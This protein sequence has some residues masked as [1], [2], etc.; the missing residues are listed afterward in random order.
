MTIKS[1]NHIEQE[2]EKSW[3]GI[4]LTFCIY[5]IF[6]ITNSKAAI[7]GYA[8]FGGS[9][10]TAPSNIS[11]LNQDTPHS[12]RWTK[13][14]MDAD[15]FSHDT[16]SFSHE[17]TFKNAGN[18]RVS[19]SI[20]L[21]E[22][23][24]GN[25]RSI[26]AELYLNGNPIDAGR[27][28]SS[29]IR[30][31]NGHTKTSLHFSSLL[32]NISVDDILELRVSK[33]TNQTG[34][35]TTPGAQ[36]FLQKIEA[37]EAI[38]FLKGDQ[39]TA[40]ADLNT[41]AERDFSWDEAPVT[42]AAYSHST[43]SN[44]NQVTF[45]QSGSYRV[46][47]NIPLQDPS[48][49]PGN[50]RTA[51]EARVRVGGTLVTSGG[52]TQG[53]IRCSDNHQFSSI[54]W[55]GY[56]H[57]VTPGQ[58]LTVDVI[59]E[60]TVYSTVNVPSG[61]KASLL[62]EKIDSSTKTLTLS[63]TTLTTGNNWNETAGGSVQ[64]T[65]QSVKDAV[66]YNHST[67][68]NSH[69]ITFSESGDYLVTYS[70]SLTST[71]ARAN[72]A[73]QLRLNN[74]LPD[75]GECRSHYIRN[76]NGH[77]QSSCSMV[78]LLENVSNGDTLEVSLSASAA[79]GTVNDQRPAEISIYQISAQEP[80]LDIGNIPNKS[81]HFDMSDNANVLDNSNRNAND[82]SFSTN[83]KTLV[84]IS[85][86][87]FPH[88]GEQ[89]NTASQPTFDKDTN[90]LNFDG[91]NDF[92]EIANAADINTGT[93]SERTFA[94][95]FRTGPDV[96]SRQMIYEEGGTV[97]G[98][99]VYIGGGN[100]YLG[101]WNDNNDGD[102]RQAFVSTS[103]AVAPNTNYYV[104]IV[105]DYSNYT[106][107]NGPNGAL[108][109]T[110]N[111]T[112]FTFSGSTTSR[113]YNHPGAIGVGAMNGGTCYHDGCPGGNGDYF[114]G[115][116]F[117]FIM[118][119]AAISPA[120]E[121]EYYNFFK[122]KW[123][124]PFPVTNLQ[125][126]DQ[127]INDSTTTP[128]ITWD[129]SISTDIDHYEVA[130]GTAPELSDVE[131][132]TNVGNVTSTTVTG[133]SLS[134]CVNYFASVKAVDPEPKES[135]LESTSFFKYDG[136]S[137]TDP[138]GL[139]L[140]SSASG[141]TSRILTWNGV[142]DNCSFERYE[143]ALGTTSGGFDIVN[144]T[145]VGTSLSHQFTGLTLSNG[146]DYY[147]SVRAV[148]SAEN[149]SNEVS[150]VAWQVD[151]CVASDVTAP[152][153]PSALTL[154]GVAGPTSSPSLSWTES[155]DSCGFSHY[156]IAIGTTSGA[157]DVQPFTNIGNVLSYKYFSLTPALNTNTDYY[158]SLKAVDLNNNQSSIISS[159]VWSLPAPGNVSSGLVL[160]LDSDDQSTFFQ[161]NDCSTG[162]VTT[163]GD[164]IG[165]W[166]DKSQS[167]NNA[168]SNA[169]N[170]RPTYQTNEFNGKSIVRFDGAND[171]LNFTNIND[172]RTVFIV[173]KSTGTT[174][175]PLM[176]HSTL[177]DWFTNDTSLVT[178]GA[179]SFLTGGTW[180]FNKANVPNPQLQTQNGQYSLYSVVTTGNVS[181]DHISSD[182]KTGGRYFGGDYVEVIVYDRALN[183]SE[184]TA[185]E[186]FLFDKWFSA[187]PGELTGL[188]LSSEYTD[189]ATVTPSLSWDHSLASDLSFYEVALGTSQGQN[190]IAGWFNIGLINNYQFNGST[191]A[192][193]TPH[194]IS[195]RA[196]DADGNR[197]LATSSGPFRFDGTAPTNPSSLVL[198]GNASASVSR[199]LTWAS[200]T[201]ACSDHVYELS[202]GTG[203]GATDAA[204]WTDVGNINTYQFSGLTLTPATNYYFNIRAKD[205]AGNLS[206]VISSSSWQVASCVATDTTAPLPPTNINATGTTELRSTPTFTWTSGSDACAFARHDVSIG[207]SAGA[208]DVVTW[209]SVGTAT[210]HQFAALATNLSYDTDY[211]FNVKSVDQ[212]NN[213]SSTL[214]SSAFRLVGP[215]SVSATNLALWINVD[216]AETL[217]QNDNCTTVANSNN[218]NVGCIKDLSGN[219]NH[220]TVNAS[221]NKPTLRTNAFNGKNA[222][223]FDGLTNEYLNFTTR[224]T[225]IRTV[226]WVL[227]ED[228]SRLGNTVPLLGDPN[229]GTTDFARDSTGG[230]FFNASTASAAVTGG[231]LKV[232]KAAANTTATTVP[233]TESAVSLV[234]TGNT[235]A[236]SFTRDLVSC[237]GNRTFGGRLAELIIF[238][239][240]LSPAE[241]EDVEDYLMSKWNL[242]N[243]S[244][245]WLGSVSTDWNNAANWSA[246]VPTSSLDCTIPDRAN[247]PVI[248]SGIA[249]CRNVNI[250]NGNLTLQGGGGVNLRFYGDFD[251]Q[252][253]T[254]TSNDGVITV[255]DNGSNY[256]NH[257]LNLNGN[258]VNLSFNKSAG[259]GVSINENTIFTSLNIPV[260]S[261]LTLRIKRDL[262][263]GLPNGLTQQGGIIQIERGV[264]F[265]IG[266]N[267]KISIS[268]GS[269]ETQGL[270][271][272][273]SQNLTTKVTM[274]SSGRWS[275]EANGG[276]IALVGFILDKLDVDGLQILGN[277]NLTALDGG[278]FTNLLKDFTT[279]VKAVTLN[280]TA[281]MSESVAVNVGFNW[282]AANSGYAGDPVPGDNY[283]TV[284]ANNCGGGSLVFD[285]WFGDFWGAPTSFDTEDKI[286]DNQDGGN[287]NVSMDIAVSPVSLK[288]FYA[289]AYDSKILLEWETGFE[290]DH[291]GF[292]IY[293]TSNP[294]DGYNQIN[295]ELIRNYRTGGEFRGKYRFEDPDL[296]NGEV[297]FYILEDV[298][299]NGD[300]EQHGPVFARPD[301]SYGNIPAPDDSDINEPIQD[302]GSINLGGGVALLSQTKGSFR[303]SINPGVLQTTTASWDSNYVDVSIPGYSHLSNAESPQLLVRKILVPVD[304]SYS[305]VQHSA[306]PPTVRDESAALGG[307]SISPAPSYSQNSD[308]ELVPFYQE[309]P[310][311][312][313]SNSYSP[314]LYYQV[315]SQTVEILNKHYV[316]ITVYPLRYIASSN[317]LEKLDQLILDIGLKGNAWDYTPPSDIYEV[318]PHIAEGS[319]RIKYSQEG[320]YKLAFSD[321]VDINADGFYNEVSIEDL[322]LYRDGKELPLK[323]Q[324]ADATFGPGDNLLFYGPYEKSHY[325]DE[326]EVVLSFYDFDV[327]D[328]YSYEAKRIEAI[329]QNN[330]S[331]RGINDTNTKSLLFADNNNAFDGMP[332]GL[333]ED[334]LY[335]VRLI[336]VKGGY[337]GAHEETINLSDLSPYTDYLTVKMKVIGSAV[338]SKNPTHNLRLQID[339]TLVESK[340]FK[341]T[342]PTMVSFDVPVSYLSNGNNVFRFSVDGTELK[343]GDIEFLFVDEIEVTYEVENERQGGQTFLRGGASRE[344]VIVNNIQNPNVAVYDISSPF[345]VFEYDTVFSDTFD[346]GSTYQVSF[347]SQPGIDG[348]GGRDKIVVENNAYLSPERIILSEGVNTVLKDSNNEYSYVIIAEPHLL[349]AAQRLA[350][351]KINDGL[352]SLAVST[353]QIYGEFSGGRKDPLALQKFVKFS[354]ENWSD[355]LDYLLIIGDASFDP[356]DDLGYSGQKMQPLLF[357]SGAQEDYGSD[358]A[359]GFPQLG[360]DEEGIAPKIAVG[361]L[362]TSNL[363][364][365]ESYIQKVI[366]YESGAK[367]PSTNAK[368][369]IFVAGSSDDNEDFERGTTNLIQSFLS[370]NEEFS[371]SY[372][373]R[374]QLTNAET[375]A[376]LITSINE[377]PLLVS[378]LGHGAENQWGLGVGGFFKNSDAEA[379]TNDKLP[380]MMGF[381]CRNTYFYN[382]DLSEISLAE[383]L[384]LNPQGGAIAFFGSTTFTGPAAQE[385]LATSLINELGRRS[386]TSQVGT[387]IGE[388]ALSSY[389]VM[390]SNIYEK[391]MIMSWALIGD[392]T[393]K[394]PESSFS[395]V[396]EAP[397]AAQPGGATPAVAS[398]GRGGGCSLFADEGSNRNPYNGWLF[399]L[400]LLL[401]CSIYSLRRTFS[402]KNRKR[403][404]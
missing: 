364:F 296:Q 276:S 46:S 177:T 71:V 229:G 108:R 73:V 42:N 85:G 15:F 213:Q 23:S 22:S 95:V 217:F 271:D 187:A 140:S 99:N 227:K 24:G 58:T 192:E 285:Q 159:P 332:V 63:G 12:I 173:N 273:L 121:I 129:A 120:L 128:L 179:S 348:E 252:T 191:I 214:S 156:E 104:T 304:E 92:Y 250:T 172:I 376:E 359:F 316:E 195:V 5:F 297:Y 2:I 278:Q 260:G 242:V 152:T 345:D 219:D 93:T 210:S 201:D 244:T 208:T 207:T 261:N 301:A 343:D 111:G 288:N 360:T 160:W 75:G 342:I 107:P 354:R 123:P 366:D 178:S 164:L 8:S 377:G 18:Y 245:E 25:R 106:G 188:A 369:S 27:S 400:E 311:A 224:L 249:T 321:I 396:E 256:T 40:G 149:L 72:P 255:S 110:I 368:K 80:I 286:Y 170:Q 306:S 82:S 50:N 44:T 60:T 329:E 308:G 98:I 341:A 241:V 193:C 211:F 402:L 61:K 9:T 4:F 17:V 198:T 47:L 222:L 404:L 138:T 35:V 77:N 68:A 272:A 162:P 21:D 302:P 155:T 10:T 264:T 43:F 212:N 277:A 234:T 184:V 340:A 161:N 97:R 403:L 199:T 132:F 320:M 37:G 265:D 131:A 367:S 180:R 112:P 134:E 267:Q 240:A 130:I 126:A 70:D 253:G 29:Y 385:K 115:D 69:R 328:N 310:T 96:T 336:G 171:N 323:I 200:A 56:V 384:V 266:A 209:T 397:P 383:K 176:G 268:S 283:Y 145:D 327:A 378:Y 65:T 137:P 163:D 389:N 331:F 190:E 239:R 275:F 122:E 390:G 181:A 393:L 371:N 292:N 290:R 79:T 14:R 370:S 300:R 282:G 379:L 59:G 350:D 194:Y 372:I 380:I 269:F 394:I 263:I 119:N 114:G 243:T 392:P 150:S 11:N 136:T 76:T 216:N 221:A 375:K 1:Q 151:T 226:F 287:C 203:P 81:I 167:G 13:Q 398:S 87:E 236:S 116:I 168:T 352:S 41:N 299:I 74:S 89:T 84:D 356:K 157:S 386:K 186:N 153:D 334:Q 144:W 7:T 36:L 169:D 294:A 147:L 105:Y 259:G 117:E 387:R 57:G 189:S 16:S 52:A 154:S 19:F 388:W 381:G 305:T 338:Y 6:G 142:S 55:F 281:V 165:C 395:E 349:A 382:S 361:R 78:Y 254:I 39:T 401:Y 125:L 3:K 204:P 307:K 322:R 183:E 346:S 312:Y 135:T 314:S 143:V 103:T 32:T 251:I 355:P 339:G 94:M 225:G 90:V 124:D 20:P 262:N 235:T 45:N 248:S 232:N 66:I 325:D 88:N 289:T 298:A 233:I 197:G 351:Y 133:L 220:L 102:G 86:S 315:A 293:R 113:L 246:G 158:L 347:K 51:V 215:G 333:M 330:N 357:Y 33:Q 30:D 31:N 148:D 100:I 291:L 64:W 109:G 280:T 284:Y 196:V 337:I 218:Q 373:N 279:P 54:H 62:I 28:E 174:Y 257:D 185:I 206:S 48:G 205:S 202:I 146:T 38:L 166:L 182:R 230:P 83:V 274:T 353:E 317:T 344:K 53:Y 237:C 319:I 175:Q 324:S 313:S 363:F 362:P 247:D 365:V 335:L 67:S 258:S 295:T 303:I 318:A 223:N 326:E 49:C 270:N 228:T 26:R 358:Q 231:T 139:A 391:D 127:F 238:E 374:A 34:D 141:S 101:F 399:V 118:Y 91:T 309:D